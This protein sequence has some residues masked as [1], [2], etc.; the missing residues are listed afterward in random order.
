MI[1]QS[2]SLSG[3]I[4]CSL[5][6]IAKHYGPLLTIFLNPSLFMYQLLVTKKWDIIL[7]F[8]QIIKQLGIVTNMI[9]TSAE[10]FTYVCNLQP[11][12]RH[13]NTY[14]TKWPVLSCGNHIRSYYSIS[15]HR[16]GKLAPI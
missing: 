15:M 13:A 1:Y 9:L 3:F 4:I 10:N 8:K 6:D 7:Y 2:L 16:A 14:V 11:F 12:K 5:R